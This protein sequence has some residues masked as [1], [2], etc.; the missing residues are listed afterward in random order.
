VYFANTT[1]N[2]LLALKYKDVFADRKQY[3]LTEKRTIQFVLPSFLLT[4]QR[5]GGKKNDCQNDSHSKQMA[6]IC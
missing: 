3:S 4:A 6:V 5:R 2:V 1:F